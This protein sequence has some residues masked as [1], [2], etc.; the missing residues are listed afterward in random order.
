MINKKQSIVNRE[1]L[2]KHRFIT[3]TPSPQ[4]DWTVDIAKVKV[5]KD[6]PSTIVIDDRDRDRYEGKQEPIEPIAGS[7]PGAVN[8][9]WKQ[10]SDEQGYLLSI[11]E[12][13]NNN[14]KLYPGGWSD[15]CSYV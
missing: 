3:F 5:D 1:W 2:I 4:A 8:S 11:P 12:Q 13:R 9:P 15:W 14:T 6:L 10:V 7:I